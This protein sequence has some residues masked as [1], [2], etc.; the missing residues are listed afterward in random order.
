MHH[1]ST[2]TATLQARDHMSTRE[3]N[4]DTFPVQYVAGKG[5]VIVATCVIKHDQILQ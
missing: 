4:M 5:V 1:S 2:D 3:E